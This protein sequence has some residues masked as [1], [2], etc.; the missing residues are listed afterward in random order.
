MAEVDVSLTQNQSGLFLCLWRAATLIA[1]FC[2][3]D[4]Y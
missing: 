1:S 3:A 2:L 4:I